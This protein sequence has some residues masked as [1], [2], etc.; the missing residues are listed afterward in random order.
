MDQ[1]HIGWE[2][3]KGCLIG[4]IER[5]AEEHSQQRHGPQAALAAAGYEVAEAIEKLLEDDTGD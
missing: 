2:T 3:F 4:I 5:R 1:S